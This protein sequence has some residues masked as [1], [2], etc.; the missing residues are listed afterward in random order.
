MCDLHFA[1]SL[2]GGLD[3]SHHSGGSELECLRKVASVLCATNGSSSAGAPP[4]NAEKPRRCDLLK[5]AE[6]KEKERRPVD[7]EFSSAGSNTC[8]SDSGGGVAKRCHPKPDP[9]WALMAAAKGTV[10]NLVSGDIS[11]P[12][13][14]SFLVDSTTFSVSDSDDDANKD[15]EGDKE[16]TR[17]APS[18]SANSPD[19][20]D[21]SNPMRPC[22]RQDAQSY[23]R[24]ISRLEQQLKAERDNGRQLVLAHHAALE[25][26]NKRLEGREED[27]RQ[28]KNQHDRVKEAYNQIIE[29]VAAKEAAGGWERT[30]GSPTPRRGTAANDATA[31]RGNSP[32]H[33]N[34]QP[35]AVGS[36]ADGDGLQVAFERSRAQEEHY[37]RK[38]EE[39]NRV[40]KELRDKLAYNGLGDTPTSTKFSYTITEF[41]EVRQAL[42]KKEA[43]YTRL[44]ESLAANAA[45]WG[46]EIKSLKAKG[47]ALSADLAAANR[48]TEGLR[49][50]IQ[51]DNDASLLQAR[52]A[53][54]EQLGR[55]VA[56]LLRD[57]AGARTTLDRQEALTRRATVHFHEASVDAL[58]QAAP[59]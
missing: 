22:L 47:E 40:V 3:R 12:T 56:V 57:E 34:Q 13:A 55:L 26:L 45:K 41:E 46:S 4:E 49:A 11:H 1:A 19:R 7:E 51:S 31:A 6:G 20:G 39:A 35:P 52:R 9:R 18:S 27:L 16:V 32:P 53:E 2:E 28:A 48:T 36:G 25:E 43:E 38:Y 50:Q 44:Q 58:T 59:L 30:S 10:T 15:C 5:G 21:S 24:Q 37:R 23:L 8:H 29:V 54:R 17:S 42:V 33:S 14:A